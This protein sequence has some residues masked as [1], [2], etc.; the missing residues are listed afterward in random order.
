MDNILAV[1]EV[2]LGGGILEEAHQVEVRFAI[3]VPGPASETAPVQVS[4]IQDLRQEVVKKN[5][6]LQ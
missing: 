5:L 6:V 2:F 3:E 1:G 4:D